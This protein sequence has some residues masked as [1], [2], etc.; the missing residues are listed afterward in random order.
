MFHV[1]A[2]PVSGM[3]FAPTLAAKKTASSVQLPIFAV[4]DV[5]AQASTCGGIK[6]LERTV[7]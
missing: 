5:T 4:L 6:I 1:F 7:V 3:N 2:H